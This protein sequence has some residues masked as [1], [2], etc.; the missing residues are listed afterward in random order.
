[1]VFMEK[2]DFE[3]VNFMV[4]LVRLTITRVTF[5]TKVCNMCL[6]EVYFLKLLAF[7]SNKI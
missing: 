6:E 3:I 5:V 2:I 7:K 1:M 4:T